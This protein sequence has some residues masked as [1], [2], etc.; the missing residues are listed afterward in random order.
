MRAAVETL[1][2]PEKLPNNAMDLIN[3]LAGFPIIPNPPW[4]EG[5]S[6][7]TNTLA[8]WE[9][10]TAGGCLGQSTKEKKK[11]DAVT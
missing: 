1:E 11:D 9:R 4:P 8:E 10:L 6:S 5:E 7:F 3:A 2:A